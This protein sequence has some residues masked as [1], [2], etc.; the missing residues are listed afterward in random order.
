M[1]FR[2]FNRLAGLFLDFEYT[3]MS[4]HNMPQW[5]KETL[6]EKIKSYNMGGRKQIYPDLVLISE[7]M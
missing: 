4:I 3:L 5:Q 2:C 1:L 6:I 7:K